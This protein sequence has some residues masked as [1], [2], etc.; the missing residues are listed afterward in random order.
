[1]NRLWEVLAILM[2]IGYS[3]SLLI[4]FLRMEVEGARW[5]EPNILI[6]RSE[7]TLFM[8]SLG[9]GIR[10]FYHLSKES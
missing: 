9:L 7:I 1:M 10:Y 3:I 6:R 4:I 8:V 5:Y 2:L